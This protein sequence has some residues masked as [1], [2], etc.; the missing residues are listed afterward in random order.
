[1]EF[2]FFK[3]GGGSAGAVVANRLSQNYDVLLLEAG[4]EPNPWF[5]VPAM[6]FLM[7]NYPSHD[8]MYKTMPQKHSCYALPEK[9][10]KKL[11]I[12]S[13]EKYW[14]KI[15]KKIILMFLEFLE[16]WMVRW[17]SF[18]GNEQH[19]LFN[20]FERSSKGLRLYC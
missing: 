9:V 3:V 12:C 17:K 2:Y 11:K 19:K 18:G 8:W 6:S 20:S 13:F 7:L 4:G 14:L 10:E 1:M 15:F 16:K 5:A